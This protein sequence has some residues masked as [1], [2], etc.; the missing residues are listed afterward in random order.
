MDVPALV[1]DVALGALVGP[2]EVKKACCS[3]VQL[4]LAGVKA[5]MTA[6]GAAQRLAL[7]SD[8]FGFF[9]AEQ[10]HSLT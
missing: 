8:G 6:D 4:R 7:D 1:A 9:F 10:A 5:L 2:V 3:R